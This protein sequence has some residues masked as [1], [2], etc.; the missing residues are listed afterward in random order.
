VG[1]QY[2][3]NLRL[4][5][6]TD[7]DHPIHYNYDNFGRLTE[8]AFNN[9]AKTEYA[10]NDLGRLS[11]LTHSRQNELLD[12]Y[13]YSYDVMGNKT[14]IEKQRQGIDEDSGLFGYSYDA[15]NRL[16]E[17][18]KDGNPLRSYNYDHF[19]NRSRMI[20]NNQEISYTYNSLNQ[21]ISSTDGKSYSYDKRG[22]LTQAFKDGNAVNAYAFGALNRLEKAFNF[23]QNLGASYTYNG[24][25][26]RVGKLEGTSTQPVLPTVGLADMS[27]NP[28]K[29]ID[30]VLDLTKQYHNLLQRNENGDSTSFTYDFGVLSSNDNPYMLDELGSPVRFGDELFVY[31]EFGTALHDTQN[32]NSVFSFTGYQ[33]DSI[34]DMLSSPS[35]SYDPKIGR[36]TSVDTHWH[37]RNMI[38]GDTIRQVQNASLLPNPLAIRQSLNLYDYGLSNSIKYFDPL[39]KDVW[40]VHGTTGIVTR[41]NPNAGLEHWNSDFVDYAVNLFGQK[42]HYDFT[43]AGGNS[44]NDRSSGAEALVSA[45]T[46]VH[47]TNP[48]TINEPIR[49]VG[50]SHGGNVA[51]EATNILAERYGIHVETLIT[52]ATPSRADF[53]LNTEVGQHVNVYNR[54]DT[55]QTAGGIDT[56]WHGNFRLL[57][58]RRT[59]SGAENIRVSTGFW[60]SFRRIHN[61]GRM[62]TNVDIW[63]NYIENVLDLSEFDN[64]CPITD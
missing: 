61:H 11:S 29:Q 10:Y 2:D 53:R 63:I 19:G 49:L 4:A 22:N 3:E 17:V 9:G 38:Y 6:V 42:I 8:K 52:I 18:T 33:F 28:T 5:Q 25:G 50:Y 39:G 58:A 13:I 45:I 47:G 26:N 43:W 15:M 55:V 23:E 30:D 14:S 41:D 35:R 7:G 62:H 21:L 32:T 56:W 64:S 46:S 59:Q 37:T 1:Y 44:Q 60:R 16:S 57:R 40:L 34:S 51:I 54:G 12:K 20:E 36:F 48:N 31:D 27:L 24:L